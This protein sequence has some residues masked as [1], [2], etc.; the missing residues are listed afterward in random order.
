MPTD[1]NTSVIYV[2]PQLRNLGYNT[3]DIGVF[4]SNTAARA[5]SS[6]LLQLKMDLSFTRSD[7]EF[8][9]CI[10]HAAAD[11]SKGFV[12][13]ANDRF[14]IVFK[15]A[16]AASLKTM[17]EFLSLGRAARDVA[18]LENKLSNADG[19]AMLQNF[20]S[21]CKSNDT[22]FAVIHSM[23]VMQIDPDLHKGAFNVSAEVWTSAISLAQRMRHTA[24]SLFHHDTVMTLPQEW[25]GGASLFMQSNQPVSAAAAAADQMSLSEMT[26]LF[27]QIRITKEQFYLNLTRIVNDQSKVLRVRYFNV[28]SFTSKAV[29]G[30]QKQLVQRDDGSTV[31][32]IT[33]VRLIYPYKF[34]QGAN[35]QLQVRAADLTDYSGI[36]GSKNETAKLFFLSKLFILETV[37]L[38][39]ELKARCPAFDQHCT[40]PFGD[41]ASTALY[42]SAKQLSPQHL[43][44]L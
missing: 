18:D 35:K 20:K 10:E 6:I 3:D 19:R 13:S 11:M 36:E 25:R 26:K 8:K 32:K 31:A 4:C 1:A 37:E 5:Q 7:K 21:W 42:D 28:K 29:K 34:E 2:R 12:D 27:N 14:V 38:T 22:A 43:V 39:D 33:L 24:Y 23:Y 40:L 30:P 41:E 15:T 9:Q 16:S 44:L 17:E